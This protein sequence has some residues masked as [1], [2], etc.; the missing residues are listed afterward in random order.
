MHAHTI[1]IITQ[2]NQ[3]IEYENRSCAFSEAKIKG[4]ESVT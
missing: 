3:I 4:H 2:C 1:H